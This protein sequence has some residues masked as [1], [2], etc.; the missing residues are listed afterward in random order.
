MSASRADLLGEVDVD[1]K[2]V[3]H[4]HSAAAIFLCPLLVCNS[5]SLP[6]AIAAP[7]EPFIMLVQ[8]SSAAT[9][10]EELRSF[11]KDPS[12]P[13]EAKQ[14]ALDAIAEK[15]ECEDITKNFLGKLMAQ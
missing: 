12:I 2:E 3:S 13:R 9:D 1:L 14:E 4:L 5:L 8:I 7:F 15:L 6:S 10:S 11:L